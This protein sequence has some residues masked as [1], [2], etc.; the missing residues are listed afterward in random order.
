MIL[1][2]RGLS[3]AFGGVKAV[4]KVDLTVNEGDIHAIIG[5]NGAGKT[6]F[7]N[8]VTRYLEVD[9]GQVIFDGQEIT[10]MNPELIC[11]KGL[12][13]SF[14]KASVFPSLTVFENVQMSLVSQNERT[15]NFFSPLEK[16]VNRETR[17]II[18]FI[19]LTN[20]TG[21]RGGLL[22]QGDKKRL[23][24]AIVLGNK[25]KLALLDEPTA[26]MSSEESRN[27]MKLI[28]SLC[29]NQGLTILFTEHDMSVV[30]GIA[31]RITV[32]H[33]GVVIADG[34][35]EEVKANKQVQK[36]YLGEE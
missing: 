10:Q 28:E 7:F 8:L 15:L 30:F 18:N 35:P 13:R 26:G 6:T 22:S 33:Q 12:V 19:G 31:R 14:Q 11:R 17:D 36:I 32:L 29:E 23:E 5:P 27:T 9:E 20:Q 16:M 34:K 24:L 25:P 2:I 1:Q 4:D 21:I 3:K